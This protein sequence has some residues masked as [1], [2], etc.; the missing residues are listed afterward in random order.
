MPVEDVLSSDTQL[1]KYAFREN[2]NVNISSR[3]TVAILCYMTRPR[4]DAS[5]LNVM[6]R[7]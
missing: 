2:R 4:D 1:S 6:L 7:E 5:G 3:R